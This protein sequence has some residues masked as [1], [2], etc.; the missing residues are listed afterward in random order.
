MFRWKSYWLRY[1]DKLW[2]GKREERLELRII[3]QIAKR[4]NKDRWDIFSEL[5]ESFEEIA[6]QRG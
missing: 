6:S 3:D 4:L 1:T 5:D 2:K